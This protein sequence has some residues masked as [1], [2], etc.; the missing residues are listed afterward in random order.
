VLIASAMLLVARFCAWERIASGLGF[1]AAQSKGQL[2]SVSVFSHCLFPQQGVMGVETQ[3][4]LTQE[5]WVQKLKSSQE[6]GQVCCAICAWVSC[7]G[8]RSSVDVV[9]AMPSLTVK[10]ALLVMI[11]APYVTVMR[12][13]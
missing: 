1:C 9:G 13:S 5:S 11:L 6:W 7:F 2:V 3:F 4:P 12:A 8:A 10:L